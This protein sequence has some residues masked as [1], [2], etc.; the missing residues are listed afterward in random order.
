MMQL[1]TIGAFG[2]DDFDPPEVLGLYAAAGCRVV[3]AYRNRSKA[4]AVGDIRRVCDDV[5]LTI[6]SLH[7]HFGDDLDPSSEDET[8]RSYTV[9]FYAFEADYVRQLGGDMVVVH[10]SPSHIPDGD[11]ENRYGQLRKSCEELAETAERL[12]VRF[13]FENMPPYHPVGSDVPRLVKEIAA[14]GSDRIIFLLDT[15]HAHMTCG[16]KI[17]I[18]AAGRHLKY[19]H[20]HDNDG[21]NDTHVLPFR[22][23]LPWDTLSSG[24]AQIGYDGVFLLEVFE[25]A[26][27]LRRLLN[28]D[29]KRKIQAILAGRSPGG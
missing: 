15:G 5:G 2:F 29:W 6:D 19:T 3:Q 12:G 25:K 21:K 23:T 27:D 22:G 18:E 13:A 26:G 16:M 7:G 4:I 24:F 28:D 1:G 8:I 20:V 10:P 14:V 11:L 17:A 9:D